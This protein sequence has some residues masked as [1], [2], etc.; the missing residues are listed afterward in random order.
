MTLPFEKTDPSEKQYTCFVCGLLF[1]EA[2]KFRNHIIEK[3]QEGR[4]YVK[5]PLARCGFP[6]R[7][8]RSHMKSKHPQEPIPTGC[9]MKAIVWKDA[10]DPKGRK[11]RSFGFHDGDFVSKKN[12]K[13]LHYRSGYELEVYK[14]LE[15]MA[16]VVKFDAEPFGIPYWFGGESKKY[17]PDVMVQFADSHVE[18]WEIKPASQTAY[19]VND[20]KWT[21]ADKFC[22]ARGWHF[23]VKTEQG[24][25]LLKQALL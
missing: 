13:K 14:C 23:E 19:E 20:A 24:I 15:E 6:V 12:G 3:H 21:A 8:V 1:K 2:E 7:C 16:S 4:E 22:E 18:I 11:K 9:Q 5:C 25:K 17:F 10:R